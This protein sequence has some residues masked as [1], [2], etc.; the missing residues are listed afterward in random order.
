MAIGIKNASEM[1]KKKEKEKKRII[2]EPP[3]EALISI[4]VLKIRDGVFLGIREA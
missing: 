3:H 4:H 1:Y 2:E